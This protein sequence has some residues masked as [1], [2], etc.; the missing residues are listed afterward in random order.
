VASTL[1]LTLEEFLGDDF[2]PEIRDAWIAVFGTISG[3]MI[4]GTKSHRKATS[5]VLNC[6][7]VGGKLSRAWQSSESDIARGEQFTSPGE[8]KAVFA[9]FYIRPTSHKSVLQTLNL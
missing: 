2:T 4:E 5:G 9:S 1:L 8:G 3:L 7:W 6:V